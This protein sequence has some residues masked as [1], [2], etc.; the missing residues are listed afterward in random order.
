MITKYKKHFIVFLSLILVIGFLLKIENI[1]IAKNQANASYE[2]SV[3]LKELGVQNL[4][5]EDFARKLLSSKQFTDFAKSNSFGFSIFNSNTAIVSDAVDEEDSSYTFC[6]IERDRLIQVAILIID[7]Y[8]SAVKRQGEIWATANSSGSVV[9]WNK[10]F[11]DWQKSCTGL[12][13]A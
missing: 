9:R 5:D 8:N 10:E 2:L 7:S 6:D 11:K 12:L 13:S 1:Y 4:T 3:Y